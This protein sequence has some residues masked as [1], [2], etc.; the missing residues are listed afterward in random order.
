MSC[1][2]NQSINCDPCAFC[3][4]PGVTCLTT[5]APIDPCQEKIDIDCVI[6]SGED[7]SCSEITNGQPISQIM[8]QA[9]SL[10]F[11]IE[12]C[13]YFEATVVLIDPPPSQY[14]FC[15]SSAANN[16]SCNKACSCDSTTSNITVY[17]LD[18]PLVTGSLLYT[19]S[20]LST[21]ASAGWYGANNQCIT[22]SGG[23]TIPG[24]VGAIQSI[25]SCIVTTTTIAPT[26]TLAPCYCYTVTI[27]E[28]SS[29]IVYV[30][31]A[32][33]DQTSIEY[34]ADT[35]VTICAQSIT[36][37][38]GY[39]V[40]NPTQYCA[41][42]INCP[43]TTTTTTLAPTTTT[44]TTIPC[45][46][47][48]FTNPTDQARISWR[49]CTGQIV[50]DTI[51]AAPDA[52]NGEFTIERR[53]GSS[54]AANN[55]KIDIVVGAPCTG[56]I[57][58]CFISETTTTEACSPWVLY[59]CGNT[60][61]GIISIKPC[62][63]NP[64]APFAVNNMYTDEQGRRWIVVGSSGT[65]TSTYNPSS[66]TFVGTS[67]L[68]NCQS[69]SV[70]QLCPGI[71][72]TVAPPVARVM[73]FSSVDCVTACTTTSTVTVYSNCAVLSIS[74]CRLYTNSGLTTPVS[75][76]GY[77]VDTTTNLVFQVNSSGF[78]VSQFSCATAPCFVPPTTTT[79]TVFNTKTI[80]IEN[81]V[82]Y[83][84]P[85]T[86]NNGLP[87]ITEVGFYTDSTS[88]VPWIYPNVSW[89]GP[90]FQFSSVTPGGTP[91]T[92]TYTQLQ[93]LPLGIR[94]SNTTTGGTPAYTGNYYVRVFKNGTQI[95][96][97]TVPSSQQTQLVNLNST[98][99]LGDTIKITLSITP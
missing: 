55:P 93:G 47:I 22:V 6:Y 33:V 44:T 45:N 34:N 40:N 36:P 76:A 75:T 66:L 4:P 78:L 39:T 51:A 3:T 15:Y 69:A 74:S 5:C 87:I 17:S 20:N 92:G 67:T 23:T 12:E 98:F 41:N 91:S 68:A 26:T 2:C 81:N 18:N 94:I 61:G 30:N 60:N 82:L 86:P 62:F 19:D 96:I 90:G 28:I 65:A 56:T 84:P 95:D 27:G 42:R 53:C 88:L 73:K 79:T 1:T 31:C 59:C 58:V 63:P 54:G 10:I 97:I 13:C 49:N 11:P 7:H 80:R 21:L 48:T 77:Y 37:N 70:G 99:V 9:L 43:T 38:I 25:S 16:G 35:I 71:T 46:C 14:T 24:V 50:S 72:T 52:N 85:Q 29:T 64:T 57:P 8:L 32:G 83:S 89:S